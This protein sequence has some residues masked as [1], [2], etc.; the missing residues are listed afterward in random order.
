M[1]LMTKFEL[2]ELSRYLVGIWLVDLEIHK[3]IESAISIEIS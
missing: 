1:R 2:L 3:F